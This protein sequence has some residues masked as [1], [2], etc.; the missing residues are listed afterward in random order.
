MANN[1]GTKPI[2]ARI[3]QAYQEGG[4]TDKYREEIIR[5]TQQAQEHSSNA[6]LSLAVA[7]RCINYRLDSLGIEI[8]ERHAQ[9]LSEKLQYQGLSSTQKD[10]LQRVKADTHAYLILRLGSIDF[11]G[12]IEE[13][14]VRD[15]R[16]FRNFMAQRQCLKD[17]STYSYGIPLEII[18]ATERELQFVEKH[19]QRIYNNLCG[20]PEGMTFPGEFR[21]DTDITLLL[22]TANQFRQAMKPKQ[23]AAAALGARDFAASPVL[24]AAGAAPYGGGYNRYDRLSAARAVEVEPASGGVAPRFSAAAPAASARP[25]GPANAIAAGR[26]EGKARAE[27]AAYIGCSPAAP[28]V[29]PAYGAAAGVALSEAEFRRLLLTSNEIRYLG[30]GAGAEAAQRRDNNPGA[31]G[32]GPSPKQ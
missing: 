6:S 7:K 17:L 14:I 12:G 21:W 5:S 32:R 11:K 31:A 8:L 29:T 16:I 1:H 10:R 3:S 23:L 13:R 20:F 26:S 2:F 9:Y 27:A 22:Q 15:E 4:L 25:A 19:A 18:Q 24:V 28:P 30:P